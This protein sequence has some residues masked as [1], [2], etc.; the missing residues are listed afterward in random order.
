MP[1]SYYSAVQTKHDC[2]FAK[3]YFQGLI[4]A[5][6]RGAQR[7]VC[8]AASSLVQTFPPE[9][10]F[11]LTRP[12]LRYLFGLPLVE[13]A[14][15]ALDGLGR[16]DDAVEAQEQQKQ[17]LRRRSSMVYRLHSASAAAAAVL[18]I[19]LSPGFAAKLASFPA[20]YPLYIVVAAV[21][22]SGAF[23]RQPLLNRSPPR[24]TPPANAIHKSRSG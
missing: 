7:G 23:K 9:K 14:L 15:V 12:N 21:A 20:Y 2:T 11:L 17:L 8:F 22:V 18:M 24:R 16:E 1:L 10:Q 19:S 4:F 6:I 5:H 13:V 3:T